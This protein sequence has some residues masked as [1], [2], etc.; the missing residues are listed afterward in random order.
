MSNLGK[1]F[2]T[3]SSVRLHADLCLN[4]LPSAT[5]FVFTLFC[6]TIWMM[7]IQIKKKE[8]ER[9]IYDLVRNHHGRVHYNPQ[10]GNNHYST[11][12][13]QK[14]LHSFAL[15]LFLGVVFISLVETSELVGFWE[16]KI[17]WSAL[18]RKPSHQVF[19][20]LLWMKLSKQ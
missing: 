9:K 14:H 16:K 13:K 3:L 11:R 8:R 19:C 5:R 7:Q 17:N 15:L 4:F 20:E 2:R 12:V 18:W 1:R 10:L 6:Y